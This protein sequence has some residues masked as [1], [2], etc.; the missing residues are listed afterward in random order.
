[1]IKPM[2]FGVFAVGLALTAPLE[3]EEPDFSKVPG[4]VID[5]SP[6]S[7]GKYIGSPSIAILPNGDYLASHDEFGPKSSEHTS[8]ISH[9]FR[10][11]DRGES[12]ERIATIDGAFWNTIF[13]H[14][15]D[16]YLIGPTHHHGDFVIRKSSDGGETWT[17]PK[18]AASGLLLTGQYHCAPMPILVH[19][20]RLWR[21]VEDAAGG[22]RWG[23]RYRAMVVS[24]PVDADLLNA[25]NWTASTY[26]AR[27]PAWLE[28]DF[29]GWLEGNAVV[30][31]AGKVVDIL[32]V[33]ANPR[34]HTA[35]IVN[36]SADGKTARFDP[37]TGFIEFPGGSKK[38]AI[39]HDPKTNRYWTLANMVSPWE[40]GGN[41]AAVRN[42]LALMCSEDLREWEVRSVVLYHP[43]KKNHAFQYVDWLFEGDDLIV[44]SRTAYDDGLGGAH[45]AHDANFMTFHRV[46]GFRD[47]TMEDSHEAWK[48]AK[49]ALEKE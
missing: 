14:R 46:V 20:G 37:K 30:T 36:I 31:P 21:G 28:G 11:T 26:V 43:N 19:H 13:V 38:F 45:N 5:Y 25:A 40:E 24:A 33:D 44:A 27:D 23:E 10:S 42:T 7:S 32:R 35:A 9:V 15:D 17:T 48:K 16:V 1:M 22:E 18:D 41:P 6:A 49:A 12:W 4:H 47:L 34:K 29:R 3:A 8:A 39:R 2:L